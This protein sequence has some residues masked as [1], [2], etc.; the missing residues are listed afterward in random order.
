MTQQWNGSEEASLEAGGRTWARMAASVSILQ[1]PYIHICV[2]MYVR[3][4]IYIMRFV[5]RDWLMEVVVGNGK[6][7]I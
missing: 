2:C 7:K 5:L 1:P 6:S 4:S 3:V